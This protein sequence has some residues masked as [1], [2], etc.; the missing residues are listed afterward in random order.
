NRMGFNNEGAVAVGERLRKLRATAKGRGVVV[1]VNIGKSRVTALE[2]AAA[3]Y[4]TSARH[5]ARWADYL[6]VNV[7]SPNTPGL[8]ELQDAEALAPILRTVREEATRATGRE[9]P[10]LVKIAPDLTDEQVGEVAELAKAER[11]AGVAATNTTITHE[12]GPGGL[13]GA[14][15]RGRALEVV[16]LLRKHL[17][18]RGVI[19]ASGGIFT[20]EH[21]RQFLDAGADL[22]TAY[23]AFVYEGPSWPGRMNRALAR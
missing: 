2:D 17:G 22:L 1:G 23:T 6:V 10:L 7:S 20:P 11:L 15:L 16:G 14:P 13:S 21:G 9:V 18:H 3:D 5:L 8:R 12:F 19:M 4:A